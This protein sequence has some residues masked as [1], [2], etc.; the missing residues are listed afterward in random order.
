MNA[1]FPEVDSL[2]AD[3]KNN[4]NFLNKLFFPR[5]RLMLAIGVVC[6]IIAVK[7]LV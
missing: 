5:V 3:I 4:T 7:F 1:N 2:I 6:I